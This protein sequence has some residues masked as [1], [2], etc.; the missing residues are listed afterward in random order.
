MMTFTNERAPMVQNYDLEGV[1]HAL[2][3]GNLILYPTDTV[4]SIGCDAHNVRAIAKL[5]EIRNTPVNEGLEIL[6][7]SIDMLKQYVAHLHP[8]LETLLIYH[9]RPLTVIYE[10]GRQLPNSILDLTGRVS[11]RLVQDEYCRA[12]IEALGRPIVAE[13]ADLR[14]GYYPDSFGTISSDVIEQVDFVARHRR[15]DRMRSE[16]SIVVRLN[17]KEDELEFLRE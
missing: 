16:L 6:V 7:S 5:R 3:S 15:T 11:I 17:N 12:L 4:W 14:Q 9:V 13:A 2:R 10:Q 8:R 1:L